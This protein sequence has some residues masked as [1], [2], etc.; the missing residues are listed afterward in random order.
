LFYAEPIA[1]L[2]RELGRLPGIGPKTAQRLAFHILKR[3]YAEV[4]ALVKALVE[5]KEQIQDCSICCNLTDCDPCAICSDVH[6]DRSVICVV[7]EPKDVLAFERMREYRGLYHVLQG[8]ISPMD[9][10]GPNDIRIKELMV[11]LQSAPVTEIILATNP[12]VEGE[13]TA[14]YLARL[15]KPSGFKVTRLARGVPEGGSLEYID[16]VTL[17]RAFEGR[18]EIQ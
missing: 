4:V 16:E 10:V 9:G 14:M 11:R 13:A 1:K 17:V 3:D 8:E 18:R 6:R 12:D 7:A 5:A 15:L 2:I